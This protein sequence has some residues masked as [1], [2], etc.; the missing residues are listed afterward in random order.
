MLRIIQASHPGATIWG[1][2][3]PAQN[4]RDIAGKGVSAVCVEWE[5]NLK[6]G[7]KPPNLRY[8]SS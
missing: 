5:T 7:G 2:R 3:E 8:L 4:R 1:S 6:V